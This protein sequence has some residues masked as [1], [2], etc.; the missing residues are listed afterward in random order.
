MDFKNIDLD[1]F[2]QIIGEEQKICIVS[3][4]SPDGDSIGSS[5]GLY[6]FLVQLGHKCTVITPDKAPNFLSW[7]DGSDDIA[8]YEYHKARVEKEI[9][10]ADWIFCLDFNALNRIGDVEPLVK[11]S[12]AKLFNIDH[13]QDPDQFANLQYIETDASSTAQL[14]YEMI[15]KTKHM[16]LLNKSIAEA[17]Y[18]GI[19][20]DTGSFRF[21]STTAST[22]LV[23]AGLIST[24]IDNAAIHQKIYD[25][26]TEARLRLLGYSIS[27][28]MIIDKEHGFAIIALS[29]EELQR[30]SYQKGD[31][32]GIVNFPL[33]IDEV[34]VS[35]FISAKDE[36]VKMSFRSKGN[37]EVNKIA[38][39]YFEGGGHTNA[40]GGISFISLTET[41]EKLTEIL[42]KELK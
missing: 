30:F 28:K 4:K 35:V 36:K 19:M 32:E 9:E 25:S 27:D 40:A 41:V 16:G 37:I 23:I 18:V 14:V 20:T 13:H 39:K 17:L 6:H 29:E 31:T 2:S 24:G 7:L 3:H 15:V 8:N 12:K 42:K 38:N 22:H 10:H 1:N 5:L 11:N 21:P 34:K 26:S 33:S